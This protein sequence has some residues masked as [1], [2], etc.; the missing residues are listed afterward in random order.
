MKKLLVVPML[1]LV[2]ACPRD[3]EERTEI[4]VDT[5]AAVADTAP[6]LSGLQANIPQAAPDTFTP[7]QPPPVRS[8]AGGSVAPSVPAAPE[9]LMAAVEREQSFS[10]F[11]YQE[12]G[13]KSDPSLSGNVAM[14]VTVNASGISE[15][16]VGDANWTS[17]AA[18]TAVNNCLNERAS[19]AWKL[20]PGEVRPGRYVVQL[21]FRGS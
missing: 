11:C 13:L 14:I 18:G 12:L 17:R 20:A 6:D 19:R 7:R 5:S 4:P 1:V 8:S 16:R 3:K 9:A 15:A 2:A 21:S 10:R